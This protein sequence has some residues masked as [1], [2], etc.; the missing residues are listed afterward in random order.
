MIAAEKAAIIK[1]GSRVFTA[2]SQPEA[3]LPIRKMAEGCDA[4][5]F[6]AW[7][8][9]CQHGLFRTSRACLSLRSRP[10]PANIPRLKVPLTGSFH[11]ANVSLAVMV[12]EDAG[13]AAEHIYSG[14]ERLLQ[15]GY[16]ARLERIGIHPTV[17]LDVSHNPDGMRETVNAI[18]SFRHEYRKMYVVLGLA[19]DK[20]AR[21]VIRELLRL[22]CSFVLVNI[23]SERS[24][25]AETLSSL[26]QKEGG[27][28]TVF[29]TGRE[30]LAYLRAKAGVDDLILVTGSFYLAGDI[31]ASET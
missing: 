22:D 29:S 11:A 20:D 14:L 23:P 3:L 21:A 28:A 1:K 17:L 19:S 16:R 4:P 31:I 13:I 26:C 25:P 9:F 8:R 12:A 24:V 2:V 6:V 18:R 5:L 10:L 7:K 27:E 30:G 15:T